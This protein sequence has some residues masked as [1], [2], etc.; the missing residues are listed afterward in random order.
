MNKKCRKNNQGRLFKISLFLSS[1]VPLWPIIFLNEMRK[2][3]IN[4]KNINESCNC[5]KKIF[6]LIKEYVCS[7]WSL[8]PCFWIISILILF[9]S[10]FI[11]RIWIYK[12]KKEA[13]S[14]GGKYN[15]GKLT[16][17][18]GEIVNFFITYLVPVISLDVES[19]PSIFMN[20]FLITIIGVYFIK[21][22]TLHY[23]VMLLLAGYYVYKDD[24]DNIVISKK[25]KYEIQI[26]DIKAE[27]IGTSNIY[28]I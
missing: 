26:G 20:L 13:N 27:Q 19:I 23:N 18:D 7:T 9:V 6:F 25:T 21:N 5:F 14:P 17:V 22:N 15:L 16:S 1:F 2:I 24:N 10:Y 3:N 11:L 28:Y 8:Q 4:F 12:M